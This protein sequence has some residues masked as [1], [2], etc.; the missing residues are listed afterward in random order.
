MKFN[1]VAVAASAALFVG[2]ACAEEAVES[3]VVPELSTFSVSPSY[4]IVDAGGCPQ[5]TP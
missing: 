3:P 5:A 4:A 2:N 1:A